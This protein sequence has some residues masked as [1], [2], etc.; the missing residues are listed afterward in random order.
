MQK[1]KT[2]MQWGG[3]LA[4]SALL[5]LLAYGAVPIPTVVGGG[6]PITL[7][8]I[9]NIIRGIGRFLVVV[10]IIIAAAMIVLGGILYMT[11]QGNDDRQKSAK[12]TIK[13]GIIGALV[14]LAVGVIL[15]TLAAIVTRSF[16]GSY[17]I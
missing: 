16:F 11:A 8:E 15:Q 5:P 4:T 6:Q 10:S 14:V 1:I 17:R 7:D 9:E 13:N 2:A 3:A 12:A